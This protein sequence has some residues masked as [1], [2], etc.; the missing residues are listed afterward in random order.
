[1]KLKGVFSKTLWKRHCC[2]KFL[3]IDPNELDDIHFIR[4]PF[5]FWSDWTKNVYNSKASKLQF[6]LCR[7][8]QNSKIRKK[9]KLEVSNSI[10]TTI[11]FP[12]VLENT[13]FTPKTSWTH[14]AQERHNKPITNLQSEK[15][16]KTTIEYDIWKLKRYANVRV[17]CM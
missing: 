17:R 2:A 4:V 5:E 3:F 9:P 15:C 10:G 6:R 14:C 12:E 13:P 7:V 16:N 1:M 11:W 8:Y